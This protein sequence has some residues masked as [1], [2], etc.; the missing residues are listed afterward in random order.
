[1]SGIRAQEQLSRLGEEVNLLLAH[2]QGRPGTRLP[3]YFSSD[4][5]LR[6][7]SPPLLIP[8]T[9][10]ISYFLDRVAAISLN[11]AGSTPAQVRAPV[12]ADP[13]RE[14]DPGPRM[15]DWAF[16]LWA[17]DFLAAIAYPATVETL[18]ITREYRKARTSR[19]VRKRDAQRHSSKLWRRFPAAYVLE[20]GSDSL[21]VD[22]ATMRNYGQ[23]IERRMFQYALIM[24]PLIAFLIWAS[25][26]VYSGRVLMR[27]NSTLR[28]A[29]KDLDA[30][31][32][33]VQREEW[34][35]YPSRLNGDVDW[36]TADLPPFCG[37][38]SPTSTVSPA[39]LRSAAAEIIPQP[40]KYPADSTLPRS[41]PQHQALCLEQ[42]SLQ[43]REK[44][45]K[46]M[47]AMWVQFALPLQYSIAPYAVLFEQPFPEECDN[48]KTRFYCAFEKMELETHRY[49][50]EQMVDGLIGAILPVVYALIGSIVSLFRAITAHAEADCLSPS[51]FAATRNRLMLGIV[52][53]TVVGL[54]S[55]TL[56][57]GSQASA[58]LPLGP[59]ALALLAGFASDR[60]FGMFDKLTERLFGNAGDGQ[61]LQAT[62]RR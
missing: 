13:R 49:G 38:S 23:K 12:A 5:Q 35:K 51:D 59:T 37:D 54:F 41:G 53:G 7:G 45:L 10:D 4:G 24:F 43:Q 33:Q 57:W 48:K 1:M 39:T 40:P 52:T 50:M 11:S 58:A 62:A 14:P 46:D 29:V 27:E 20:G 61:R 21:L 34:P 32:L 42:V 30:Q 8:P 25:F 9:W 44:Q 28:T 19:F 2:I 31:I 17:R 22:T 16:L 3:Q 36:S 55:D 15:S 18:I 56:G 26:M 6:T 47:H 60:V